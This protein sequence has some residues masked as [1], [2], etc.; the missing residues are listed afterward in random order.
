MTTLQQE[1]N[2]YAAEGAG[3][4]QLIQIE[5][6]GKGAWAILTAAIVLSAIALAYSMVANTKA[7]AIEKR[8][9]DAVYIAQQNAALAREDVRVLTAELNKRGIAISTS[10]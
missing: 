10:H 4:A 9:M 1:F 2:P 5:S 7:E 8:S 6:L 3:Q